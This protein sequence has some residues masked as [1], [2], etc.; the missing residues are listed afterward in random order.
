VR[1]HG[2]LRLRRQ[3]SRLRMTRHLVSRLA[4]LACFLQEIDRRLLRLHPADIRLRH[5]FN[6]WAEKGL[7]ETMESD[8][9]WFTERAL[10]KMNLSAAARILDLGCGE[11]C[12]CRL[13]AARSG[14]L[15][16]VVG[17][18]VSDEMVRRA[19]TKS[20]QFERIAFL[21]GSAERIPCRDA[22]FTDVMSV[23]AFYYFDNQESVLNEL[24]RVLAP[25]G[26][27]LILVGLY[28]GA[29]DWRSLTRKLKLPVHVRSADEYKSILHSTGW[30][31]VETQELVQASVSNR[32][33]VDHERMLLVS[34]RRPCPAA[35]SR[36]GVCIP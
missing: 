5:E 15:C 24:F 27:L 35:A 3:L 12:A 23:S 29:P 30:V 11:G 16:R 10:D 22:V 36:T 34:A 14:A 20:R 28:K 2:Y 21:C 25:G 8:H 33:T 32:R 19:W 13:M 7:G 31:D 9:R 17:L 26:R 4:P 6:L 18:D 1:L